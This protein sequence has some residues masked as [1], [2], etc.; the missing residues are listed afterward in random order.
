MLIQLFSSSYLRDAFEFLFLPRTSFP[1]CFLCALLRT[2]HLT[3]Q[4]FFNNSL[5]DHPIGDL[6]KN[7]SEP[8]VN[9]TGNYFAAFSSLIIKI[10]IGEVKLDSDIVKS[11]LTNDGIHDLFGSAKSCIH[12][13]MLYLCKYTSH[14]NCWF[15]FFIKR[16]L[17]PPVCLHL[18]NTLPS[19]TDPICSSWCTS[20]PHTIPSCIC[21]KN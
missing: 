20:S 11:C 14:N 7:L 12:H 10:S 9:L 21:S 5:V 3:W 19:N 15:L 16:R 18:S 6:W 13:A 1:T 8:G 2:W 4:I 17:A